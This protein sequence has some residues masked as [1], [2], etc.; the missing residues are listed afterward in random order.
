MNKNELSLDELNKVAGGAIK[1]TGPRLPTG[2]GPTFPTDPFPFPIPFI[3]LGP[4]RF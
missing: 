2:T 1:Q 3:P 4:F